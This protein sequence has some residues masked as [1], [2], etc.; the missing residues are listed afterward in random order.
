MQKLIDDPVTFA[1]AGWHWLWNFVSHA[2]GR[3]TL[4]AGILIWFLIERLTGSVYDPLKR[5]ALVLMLAGAVMAGATA[6]GGWKATAG[7]AP[8]F[9]SLWKTPNLD[10]YRQ[11]K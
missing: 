1:T 4:A 7:P 5:V 3:L 9:E 6:W 10:T 2:D 11:V 8:S